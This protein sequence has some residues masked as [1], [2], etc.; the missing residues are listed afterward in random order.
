MH[1]SIRHRPSPGMVVALIALLVALGGVAFASIPGPGGVVKGCYSKS[2]GS[3][4]VIDSKKSCS[5]KRERSLSWNQQGVRGLQGSQGSQGPAGVNGGQGPQGDSGAPGLDGAA[6]RAQARY[7][8]SLQSGASSGTATDLPMIGNTWTQLRNEGD[9][10]YVQISDNPPTTCGGGPPSGLTVQVSPA[11][12]NSG[13]FLEPWPGDIGPHTVEEKPVYVFATGSNTSRT[14]TVKAW[15]SCTGG[16][17]R[18]TVGSVKADV[19]A[20]VAP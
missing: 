20:Y 18:Y 19:G 3:L 15:D 16:S 17:E 6:L 7:S 12:G 4:R 2:T 11:T 1:R 5:K 10:I 14:L 9:V 13:I 8:G